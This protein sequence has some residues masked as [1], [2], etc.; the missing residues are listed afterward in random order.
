MPAK[1]PKLVRLIDLYDERRAMGEA[2]ELTRMA[3]QQGSAQGLFR[4]VRQL[5]G[6]AVK[7][8]KEIKT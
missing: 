6:W 7:I 1:E 2:K 8:L 4:P 3:L 5:N